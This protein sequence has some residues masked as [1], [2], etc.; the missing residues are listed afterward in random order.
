MKKL[1]T[2]LLALTLTGC[3]TLIPKRVELGQD[4][5]ERVPVASATELEKQRRAAA[6]A[7]E[8][9]QKTL[10]AA[11]GVDAPVCVTEP[12]RATADL[13]DAVA[14]S[15]GPPKTPIQPNED[16]HK[17]A[18]DLRSAVAK[19]N[20]RLDDFKADNDKNAGKKI[21]DTGWLK[22]PYF[23][24]LGGFLVVGFVGL[25]VLGVAWSFVKMYAMSNPPVQL[26]VNAV[27]M[28]ANFLKKAVGEIAKGGE[29]FKAA[30]EREVQDPALQAKIKDLFRVEHERAQSSEVQELVKAITPKEPK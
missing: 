7:E 14:K 22:V 27:Q 11:I 21:E 8:Q 24:W 15:V 23:L 1:L 13:T 4:K 25:I 9:A 30:V 16:P 20:A 26:G 17:V 3:G 2:L 28:G 5:V 19:L 6:M 29:K 18:N 10:D 12:A